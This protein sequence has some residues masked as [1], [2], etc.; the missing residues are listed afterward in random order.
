MSSRLVNIRL[1]DEY[2]RKTQVLRAKGTNIS[3]LMREAIDERLERLE[4]QSKPLDVNAILKRL[5]EKYP[6]PANLPE[7]NYDVHDRHQ[8][9]EAIVRKLRG[10]RRK[11]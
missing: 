4:K 11:P 10:K 9:R 8:A 6:D 7:P 2:Y 5:Y 3:A 1:D